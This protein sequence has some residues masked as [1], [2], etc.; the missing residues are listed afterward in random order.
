M[1]MN[2]IPIN[3]IMYISL[4]GTLGIGFHIGETNILG[5]FWAYMNNMLQLFR[6]EKNEL[7]NN[8]RSWSWHLAQCIR[9]K[10]EPMMK[11]LIYLD[12]E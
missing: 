8:L 12:K 2:N 3:K 11:I 5:A 9:S 10:D 4:Y 7:T 1:I 6:K